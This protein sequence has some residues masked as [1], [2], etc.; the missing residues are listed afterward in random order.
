MSFFLFTLLNTLHW[1]LGGLPTKILFLFLFLISSQGFKLHSVPFGLKII[2]D[3]LVVTWIMNIFTSK[4]I[5]AKVFLMCLINI[6]VLIYRFVLPLM[7]FLI[8]NMKRFIRYVWTKITI[9][10]NIHP[11]KYITY[12]SRKP[13]L[14]SYCNPDVDLSVREYTLLSIWIWH[15]KQ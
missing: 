14:A 4:L 10:S 12:L 3:N 2:I 15:L 9:K 8:S 5:K 7:C 6:F 11:I 1:Y 13:K